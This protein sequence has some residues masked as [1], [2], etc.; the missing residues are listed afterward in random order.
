MKRI[1]LLTLCLVASNAIIAGPK[2]AQALKK[3]PVESKDN[4]KA[5][6]EDIQIWLNGR[7]LQANL[8]GAT[9]IKLRMLAP[10]VAELLKGFEKRSGEK[11]SWAKDAYKEFEDELRGEKDESKLQLLQA[12]IAEAIMAQ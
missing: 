6:I 9:D 11:F 10:Q 12:H 3:G 1:V 7:H 8:E 4:Q 5:R 2:F